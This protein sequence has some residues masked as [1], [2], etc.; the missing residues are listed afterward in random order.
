MSKYSTNAVLIWTKKL[1]S[2]NSVNDK[3]G[4]IVVDKS[5]FSVYVTGYTFGVVGDYSF[6]I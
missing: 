3:P 5:S 2:L 1:G 6:G 4:G